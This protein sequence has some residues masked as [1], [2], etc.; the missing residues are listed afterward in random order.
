MASGVNSSSEGPLPRVFSLEKE[1]DKLALLRL[2]HRS[3]LKAEEKNSIRDA[4]FESA[5][6]NDPARAAML[7][8]ALADLGVSLEG[9]AM[10]HA[11]KETKPEAAPSPARKNSSFGRRRAAPRFA[12]PEAVAP[13]KESVL[14]QQKETPMKDVPAPA[15]EPAPLAPVAP[16]EPEPRKES[17]KS[18]A[19]VSLG[20]LSSRI[21]EIKQHVNAK[22]GNPVSLM[23]RDAQKGR[24]YMSALLDAMKKASGGAPED[25]AAARQ[26]LE[27][28]YAD[29]VPLLDGSAPSA[30]QP[31]APTPK[32]ESKPEPAAPKMSVPAEPKPVPAPAPAAPS[33]APSSERPRMQSVKQN[34]AGAD[35]PLPQ[36]EK[37]AAPAAIPKR[38]E[39]GSMHSVAKE[40][41]LQDLL[42]AKKEEEMT[43]KKQQE[44]AR[45]AAMDPL[46]TPEVSQGLSQLLSEWSLFKSSGF[47]GTGP[48][49]LEHPLY[50]RI[51]Q[52]TMAAVIAG[53][54]E[55]ATPQVKQNIADYMNGWRYEEGVLHEHT[56]TFEHY[57]RRVIKHILEKQK[58]K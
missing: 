46:Q 29:I 34:L 7:S 20:D 37:P 3:P 56:E 18:Q 42:R 40:K 22:V 15:P 1:S 58:R 31:K 5:R 36:R 49:G 48:S 53:R 39:E 28:A 8:A 32:A 33:A 14:P 13:K 12:A 52:L 26:R 51:A 4:V 54:F 16:L 38:E 21:S 9:S 35:A 25:V 23:D 57:L 19:E 50:K 11:A 47:L 45:I 41:Q 55:G 24:E 43:S 30:P 17:P 27:K 6:S 10:P 2:V 44:E